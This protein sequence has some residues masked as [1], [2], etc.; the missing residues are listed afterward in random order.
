MGRR[1]NNDGRVQEVGF[2]E[3]E[4]GN[5]KIARFG[6]QIVP[7]PLVLEK[8]VGVDRCPACFSWLLFRFFPDRGPA[9]NTSCSTPCQ[10][11]SPVAHV[12]ARGCAQWFSPVQLFGTPW[13]AALQAPCIHSVFQARILERV[14]ILGDLPHPGVESA[15][16]EFP[17]VAGGFFTTAHCCLQRYFI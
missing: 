3:T 11:H 1:I 14:V 5:V 13:T 2:S 4:R 6:T 17:T 7:F 8:K 16:L 9:V 12:S 15:S 10:A